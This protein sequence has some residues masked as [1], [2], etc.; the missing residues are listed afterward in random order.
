MVIKTKIYLIINLIY[1]L[2]FCALVY[3]AYTIG[4]FNNEFHVNISGAI[5]LLVLAYH[6][7]KKQALN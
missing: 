4:E 1:G 5:F 2:V 3:N 6:L 7:N